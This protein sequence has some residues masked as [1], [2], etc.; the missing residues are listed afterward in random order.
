MI[1]HASKTYNVE[2]R[3]RI[4]MTFSRS[5]SY[6]AK[7]CICVNEVRVDEPLCLIPNLA[8]H[9]RTAEERKAF[10]PNSETELQ[11]VLC[12]PCGARQVESSEARHQAELL[13]LVAKALQVEPER[14]LDVDLCLMD[15]TPPCRIGGEKRTPELEIHGFSI[16][17]FDVFRWFSS[18]FPL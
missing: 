8:I 3:F 2:S 17:F 15:T 14:L 9:L 13:E 16:V 11:P 1:I 7:L 18:D 4:F 6:N 5:T 12:P 10:A